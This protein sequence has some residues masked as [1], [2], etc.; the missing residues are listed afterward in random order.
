MLEILKK[1]RSNAPEWFEK[2]IAEYESEY[3][4]QYASLLTAPTDKVLRQQ[5]VVSAMDHHLAILKQ[6]K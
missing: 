3:L 4:R 6:V 2:Y 1:L 5:G